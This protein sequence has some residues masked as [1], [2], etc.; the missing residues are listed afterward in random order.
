MLDEAISISFLRCCFSIP[1][2]TLKTYKIGVMTQVFPT[3]PKVIYDTLVA[4]AT[5]MGYIG[6]YNFRAGQTAPAISIVTPGADLPAVKSTTGVE[7]VIHDTADLRRKDYLTEGS[8]IEANWTVFLIC[9][10][11]ATGDEMTGATIRALEIFSGANSFETVSVADGIGAM[12]QT[13]IQIPSDRP[14]LA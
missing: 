6:E 4:D 11:P 1:A 2:G 10:E 9:W 12:V 3:N 14:I 7:V 5:F 8:D 13:A